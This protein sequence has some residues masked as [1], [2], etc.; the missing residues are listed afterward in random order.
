ML[1]TVGN[2]ATRYGNQTLLDGNLIIGTAGKGIDFSADPH[3]PGMTSELLDD[4]EEGTWTPVFAPETGAFATL[5][6]NSFNTKYIKI[7]DQVTVVAGIRTIDLD[8]TGASGYLTVTGLPFAAS[9]TSAGC[10]TY[11]NNWGTDT[12]LSGLIIGT[13][14]ELNKRTTVNGWDTNVQVSD[15][16]AAIG[17][18]KN[19]FVF[20]ATYR[21]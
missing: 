7:G 19:T 3:S 5:T 6:M 18:N 2:P 13:I 8:K 17:T 15:L 21:V 20:S 4:Y 9:G 10:I 1:K 11:A 14:V 16:A 12:P